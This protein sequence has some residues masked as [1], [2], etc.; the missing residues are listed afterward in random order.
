MKRKRLMGLITAAA[1][2]MGMLLPG[3]GS[4]ETETAS[5]GETTQAQGT[6]AAEEVQ[7]E[8]VTLRIATMD[9]P[10]DPA[11][12]TSGLPVMQALEEATNVT[13]EWEVSPSSQYETYTQTILA[14]AEDMPDIMCSVYGQDPRALYDAGLIIDLKPLIDSVGENTKKYLEEHP[15]I[16]GM[17]TEPDGKILSIPTIQDGE[18]FGHGFMIRKDWLGKLGLEVPT[19][20]DELLEVLRAFK[21]GDPNGNGQADEIP[22]T[23]QGTYNLDFS[24]PYMFCV[25][26]GRDF[27]ADENGTVFFPPMADEFKEFLKYMNTMYEEGLLDSMFSTR[28]S[29]EWTTLI[30][31]DKV[32]LVQG[33]VSNLATFNQNEGQEWV[34]MTVP[35]GPSGESFSVSVP[36]IT[37][38][39]FITKDC[40]NPEAAFKFLDYVWASEEGQMLANYGIEGTSYEMVDGEPQ[41]TDFVLNNPDGL[42][43]NE[44][45]LSLGAVHKLPRIS[46]AELTIAT[47]TDELNEWNEANKAMMRKCFPSFEIIMTPEEVEQKA[48]LGY[49][50]MW[51]YK[52]EMKA[53]F[54]MG[55][56][57]IDEYWDTYIQT[58][59]DMGIDDVLA[60]EQAKYDRYVEAQSSIE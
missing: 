15:E 50:D 24:W 12:Y 27:D 10:Y 47:A 11:S 20:T 55:K 49:T 36:T 53:R 28:T 45:L 46:G 22:C 5:S 57:D 40:E 13:I 25:S 56:D 9:N 51:T 38:K 18:N 2:C 32:G 14:A 3:C 34:A 44:A 29:E 7:E 39:N 4:K 37:G 31:T 41:F 26:P 17:I 6:E 16:L 52:E 1:L 60:I 30:N 54:I 33:W 59:K 23:I 48:E 42:S 35:T 21:T 58:L 43:P 19:T 8:P